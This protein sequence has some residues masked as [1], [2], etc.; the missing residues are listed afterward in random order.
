MEKNIMEDQNNLNIE[1]TESESIASAEPTA[2]KPKSKLPILLGVVAVLI[3]A[4]AVALVLLLGGGKNVDIAIKEDSMPQSIFVLGEELDLSSGILIVDEDG[5][6]V[7]IAMNA[8][9][10]SI[11]GYDKNTLGEQT[12]T[13]TYKEKSVEFKVTVVERMQVVDYISDY[14]IDDTFDL[15]AG[16]V[17][18]TR[19]DGSNYT[20]ILKSDKVKIDG[21]SSQTAGTK[22][23]T[24]TYTS[25]SDSYTASF[26][27]TV[28]NVENVTLTKPTKVTYNSHD[29]GIDVKGGILTLTALGGKVSKDVTVTEDM[30]EGFDLSAVNDTNTPLTQ[31]V[32][33]KYDGKSYPYEIVI[34]YTSVSKFKD[35]AGIASGFTWSGEDVPEISEQNGELAVQ[36]MQ[37]YLDMSP[38]EQTLLTREETIN[39]ARTAMIYAYQKWGKDVYEFEGAFT[40]VDGQFELQCTDRKSVEEA[41]AK[42]KDTDRPIYELYDVLNGMVTVF[43]EETLFTFTDAEYGNVEMC[44]SDYSTVDPEFFSL[45]GEIFEY[46]LELDDLMDKVG[47]DW[48]TN[49]DKYAT[50][51]EDVYAGIVNS[52][53]YSYDY[54]QFFYYVS[55]WRAEDDAF[56][57]LYYYYYEVKADVASIINIA[58]LRLPSSLEPIFAHV[59]EAMSQMELLANYGATDTTQFFYHY[60]M[61][62][63]L[64]QELLTS[65]S[66]DDQ[67]NVALFYGLPLNS[68]LGISA[69][70]LYTF[71]DMISYLSTAEGGYYPLCG[72]LLDLPEFDALLEKYLDIIIKTFEDEAYSGSVAYVADVKEMLALYMELTPSQQYCFLGTLNAF[73]AMNIPPLAFD[74]TGEY[75]D[76]ICLF[77]DMVNEVYRDLFET[78]EGKDAYLALMLA[79]EAYAQRFTSETWL[80]TFRANMKVVADALSGTAMSSADKTLF[81]TELGTIYSDYQKLL[82]EYPEVN[83]PANPEQAPDLGVWA[84]KF[85]ELEDAIVGV[86]LS[87]MLIQQGYAMYDIFFSAY[88]RAQALADE[89]M[90]EGSD[91]IKYIFIHNAL[92]SL[93]TL[94]RFLDPETPI[95]PETEIFWSYDYVISVYRSIYVNMQVSIGGSIY[96]LYRQY[97]MSSFLNKTYDLIWALMWSNEGDTE[98]FEKAK[99][100]DLMDTFSKMD[101]EAQML[102]VLYIEGESGM[103]YESLYTF[104]DGYSA[105]VSEAAAAL[106]D[107]EMST[108]SYKYYA[109]LHESGDATEEELAE[110][111]NA[112][113]EAYEIFKTAYAG[114]VTPEELAEFADFNNLYEYYKAYVEAATSAGNANA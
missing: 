32:N 33:V 6:Q 56:D 54:A 67:M 71:N 41:I 60:Y 107:V 27:V 96:D 108:I 102:F 24:A 36:M 112:L 81:N 31:T 85:E 7:E 73:Y 82:A 18:I 63:K 109:L 106:L 59:Y 4:I 12:V 21:F 26:E 51:I 87:Y 105:K 88:E 42:L 45:L 52:E 92:Y 94:D 28:H 86:E 25:G 70:E 114:L 79:T 84:D 78:Q 103:Y 14:L 10:V 43:A 17:K 83:D 46:M 44:F 39:M 74:N 48:L 5:K 34:K 104:L 3:A 66:P 9:G 57:F 47:N 15:S 101:L 61:A 49:I 77:V 75:A 1:N 2:K 8:E 80:D 99:I 20:V 65:D 90:T 22:T 62:C 53:F 19:N 30:I 97:N 13:V 16:R 58:N 113:K 35:N 69:D 23:V 76:L 91:E 110:A 38:A 68:M 29:E 89:I 93:S 11:S 100:L 111:L 50:Q 40:L 64:A 55:M 37:L 72:S 98:I 95:D